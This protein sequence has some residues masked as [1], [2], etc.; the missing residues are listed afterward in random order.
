MCRGRTFKRNKNLTEHLKVHA[1]HGDSPYEPEAG[2][3]QLGPGDV[4]DVKTES[5]MPSRGRKRTRDD[6]LYV[7]TEEDDG[8]PKSSDLNKRLKRTESEVGKDWICDTDPSCDKKFKT[9]RALAV[10]HS[11]AHLGLRPFAC[12]HTECDNTY[13][14]KHLLQR[15]IAARHRELGP[16]EQP[17]SETKILPTESSSMDPQTP[18]KTSDQTE[19][20]HHAG[21]LTGMH[22]L[23][24]IAHKPLSCPCDLIKDES[25]HPSSQPTHQRSCPRRFSRVYDVQ[26]HLAKDH[27]LELSEDETRLMLSDA[28]AK[29]KSLA[30]SL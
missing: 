23:Q 11:T 15:H 29:S 20:K 7:D 27:H 5:D 6:D 3:L 1:E 9:K 21:L 25:N 16:P 2:T 28:T 26:R 12:P 30:N 19:T 14:H 13:G 4:V 22:A 17:E 10:H 18:K 24:K 8:H